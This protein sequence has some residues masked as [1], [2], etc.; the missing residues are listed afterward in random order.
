M[1]YIKERFNGKVPWIFERLKAFHGKNSWHNLES[2]Y[3]HTNRVLGAL[4]S[5]LAGLTMPQFEGDILREAAL[6]HDVGKISPSLKDG[7]IDYPGHE[8]TSAQIYYET[9]VSKTSRPLASRPDGL[10]FSLQSQE[11][12]YDLII[13]HT[14]IHKIMGENYFME[15]LKELTSG[16]PNLKDLRFPKAGRQY[17]RNKESFQRGLVLLGYSD[18]IA[19]DFVKIDPFEFTKRVTRYVS[20]LNEFL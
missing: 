4:E 2:V 15:P 14:I 10:R 20:A 6:Y 1:D 5:L 16:I 7:R 17:C 11:L 8:K 13:N 9:K 19:S 3:E 18:I 12:V